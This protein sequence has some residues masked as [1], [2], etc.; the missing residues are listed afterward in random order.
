MS[1]ALASGRT[2]Y[3]PGLYPGLSRATYESID[4]IN[5]S[6]LAYFDRTASHARHFMQHPP[7]P[8]EAMEFGTAFHMAVL[9]QERFVDEYIVPPECDRR[10]R[11]G[12]ATWAEFEAA[13]ADQ[14][15]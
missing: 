1:V 13:H 2:V 5:I 4:A 8:S 9:E 12:K 15:F 10:T 6:K 7:S 14:P 3:R 11:E